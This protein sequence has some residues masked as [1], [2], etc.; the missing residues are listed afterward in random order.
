MALDLSH[1]KRPLY[2][3]TMHGNIV[4]PAYR[5]TDKFINDV[6]GCW[7]RE[8]PLRPGAMMGTASHKS[9]IPKNVSNS[10]LNTLMHLPSNTKLYPIKVDG[11]SSHY[12]LIPNSNKT[13][14]CKESN[15]WDII[16]LHGLPKP[17]FIEDLT[18]TY[19]TIQ[20]EYP[21]EG[22]YGL[23]MC[24]EPL[25]LMI[26]D[27]TRYLFN[28][29]KGN[30]RDPEG[31]RGNTTHANQDYT[32]SGSL[33]TMSGIRCICNHN[34]YNKLH[35][36]IKSILL[37]YKMTT[38]VLTEDSMYLKASVDKLAPPTLNQL[39]RAGVNYEQK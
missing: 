32:L 2:N 16:D 12:T 20:K 4:L 17:Q 33:P 24:R 29:Y 30:Y 11:N 38:T 14:S 6:V 35:P 31:L 21:S 3:G 5:E 26:V 39:N 28:E 13:I 23:I 37:P 34:L 10:S 7:T 15:L 22:L 19:N 1:D 18:E 36:Y 9:S 27:A 8:P 25:I